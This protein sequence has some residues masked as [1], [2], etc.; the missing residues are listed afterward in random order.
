M[1]KINFKEWLAGR[2]V[3]L[4][5]VRLRVADD[6]W[7]DSIA[8]PPEHDPSKWISYA[9][10]TTSAAASAVN[11]DDISYNWLNEV[12]SPSRK[13]ETGMPMNDKLGMTLLL[14]E[15]ERDDEE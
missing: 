9:F 14:A 2:G 12:F 6:D 1:R 10:T 4:E 13:I 5:Y 15:L 11:W 7:G 3:L 8:A